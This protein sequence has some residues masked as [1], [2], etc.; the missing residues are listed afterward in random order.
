MECGSTQA[1]REGVVGTVGF[2]EVFGFGHCPQRA[3]RRAPRC[4]SSIW[5]LG[6]V[7]LGVCT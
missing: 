2:K 6:R 5:V 7:L 3:V 1:R 4:G